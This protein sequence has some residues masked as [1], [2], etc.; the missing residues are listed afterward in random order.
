[1]ITNATFD[2]QVLITTDMVYDPFLYSTTSSKGKKMFRLYGI[3]Y[4]NIKSGLGPVVSFVVK[5]SS[6][7][8]QF[9]PANNKVE[10]YYT[11]PIEIPKITD[12][13]FIYTYIPNGSN[14]N[15]IHWQYLEL[16]L[17]DVYN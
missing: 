11:E 13:A 10:E 12:D 16:Q 6:F 2:K 1:M 3:Y 7:N 8:F 17:V 14:G 9:V 15:L 4:D 5:S